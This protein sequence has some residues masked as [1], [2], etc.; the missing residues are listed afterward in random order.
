MN[1]KLRDKLF[2]KLLRIKGILIIGLFLFSNSTFSIS[3]NE[4]DTDM[5]SDFDSE[6]NA[7]HEIADISFRA[8]LK[9]LTET[10]D[11]IG[12]FGFID[13]NNDSK[14]K[15]LLSYSKS[16]KSYSNEVFLHNFKEST[17]KMG[18]DIGIGILPGE[19]FSNNTLF[20]ARL[21]YAYGKYKNMAEI[22]PRYIYKKREGIRYGLGFKQDLNDFLAVRIDYSQ[23]NSR[24]DKMLNLRSDNSANTFAK[25]SFFAPKLQK[26]E[27][28][29]MLTY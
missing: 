12:K 4:F 6:S 26:L 27:F 9:E 28:G 21:G 7:M 23:T 2:N 10:K 22:S 29:L 25:S 18:R 16:A 20:Y 19:L 5:D 8:E 11:R 17:F 14:N 1:K 24:L 15:K 13:V 3:M